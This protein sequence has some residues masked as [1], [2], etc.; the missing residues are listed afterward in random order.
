MIL[1]DLRPLKTEEPNVEYFDIETGEFQQLPPNQCKAKHEGRFRRA[2]TFG[3]ASKCVAKSI[4]VETEM[5]AIAALEAAT[6]KRSKRLASPFS[7]QQLALRNAHVAWIGSRGIEW[8]LAVSLHLPYRIAHTKMV[9][10]ETIIEKYLNMF[11]KRVEK[12]IFNK[13]ERIRLRKKLWRIVAVENSASVGFHLHMAMVLPIGMNIHKF[14]E[15]LKQQ[16]NRF[17]TGQRMTF[18]REHATWAQ[19][20]SGD[21]VNYSLKNVGAGQAEVLWCSSHI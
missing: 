21:Y 3:A 20:L 1:Q 6:A 11:F 19:A 7:P 14:I 9:L 8:D 16:W 2:G 17:W 13:T 10:P 5:A 18:P 12:Q 15:I 4:S